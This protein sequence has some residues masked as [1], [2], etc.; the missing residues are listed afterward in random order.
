MHWVLSLIGSDARPAVTPAVIDSAASALSAGDATVVEIRWL[1]RGIAAEIVFVGERPSAGSA[2]QRA[3]RYA[4]VD[5]V[6]QPAAGRRKHL[7]V[8]DLESTIIAQECLEEL[9]A[10]VGKRVEIAAITN[11]AMRGEIDFEGALRERVAMLGGLAE[12]TLQEVYD[13]RVSLN[14]GAATLVATMRRH[15]ATV[16]LVSGGFTFFT[17]RIRRA[18]GCDYDQGNRLEIAAGRLTGSVAEPILGRA[19][20]REALARLSAER[21]LAAA[22]TMAVGDGANDLEMLRAA[23]LGVAYHAK[24]AVAEAA[25]ARI[26]H[27]D[28]TA[29]LY[30]QGYRQDEFVA[31]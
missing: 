1:A 8:A 20:K 27:G 2:A 7:L 30:L 28:L 22:D 25:A 23:G 5:C 16:A 19:A 18:L 12:T 13:H 29:L 17:E 26:D 3:T 24:P 11:R 6:V 14:P 31:A 9:A 15:G 10:Y 21:G 4:A